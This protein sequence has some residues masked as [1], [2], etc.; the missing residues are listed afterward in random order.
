MTYLLTGPGAICSAPASFRLAGV[1]REGQGRWSVAGMPF[2]PW[3][4]PVGPSGNAA[5]G[6]SGTVPP[7]RR[8]RHT[9]AAQ[10]IE[11]II[12]EAMWTPRYPP[13]AGVVPEA[14]EEP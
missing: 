9:S 6:H 5:I 3:R 11:T 8:P 12:D 1:T 7:C 10:D 14:G 4:E 2:G 13:L